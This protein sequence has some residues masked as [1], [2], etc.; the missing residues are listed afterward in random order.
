M[1]ERLTTT[2]VASVSE[3][4]DSQ[5]VGPGGPVL[6]LE[7]Q[8]IEKLAH[9]NRGRIPEHVIHTN[10]R[11]RHVCILAASLCALI[12]TRGVRTVIVRV[13][14]GQALKIQSLLTLACFASHSRDLEV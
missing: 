3:N 4:Q 14:R 5:T 10:G 1:T 8:F 7:C 2:A 9:Q 12:K 11:V 6:L 13:K